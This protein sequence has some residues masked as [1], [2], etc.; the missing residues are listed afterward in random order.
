MTCDPRVLRRTLLVGLIPAVWTVVLGLW[1]LS[2]Q[3]SVWR[4]EAAT[5]QVARRSTGDIVRMLE[6]VDVV[7]SLYYLCMHG[8]FAGFGPST[9]VLRLPSVLAVAAAAACV[10]LIGHRLAGAYVGLGAGLALGLL[11][12]VQFYLQEGRPY[13]LVAAGSAVSTL[14]LVNALRGRARKRTWAAYACAVLVCGWLNW[15]ALLILPAHL[16]T[17]LWSRAP[18]GVRVRWA[19]AAGAAT[20]GVLPLALF[21]L[22]QSGQVSWVPPLTWHMM[23]G[24]AILLAIGG[25]GGLLGRRTGTGTA[26]GTGMGAAERTGA[27]DRTDRTG[28]ADRTDLADRAGRPDR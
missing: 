3:N 12:A 17:L 18:R 28:R 21:S 5:W 27:A 4:D 7:H 26:P 13:A 10:A 16:I 23:I 15:L 20:A 2:R 22:D 8:L 19:V 24:P 14:L 11:P 9:T 25:L 6:H 1:G